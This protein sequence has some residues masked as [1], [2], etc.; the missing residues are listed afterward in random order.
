MV[1]LTT[2]VG[3][4]ATSLNAML[5]QIE[6]SFA[7]QR[8][9]EERMRRFVSDASHE[10]RTPLATVRGYGELYRIGGIPESQVSSAMVR[11]ESEATRMTG[12]VSDLLQLA[13]LDEGR[14]L[15]LQTV[16]LTG[17]ADDAAADVRVLDP[18]R[19][20]AV[21]GPDG[22]APAPVHAVADEQRVRQIL[23]N[24]TENA[25]MHTP[26]GT[27]VEIA[28]GSEGRTAVLEVRDHGPGV[29]P[30]ETERIFGRFYRLDSSRSR[31]SGGS[32]LGLAIVAAI[33]AAHGGTTR[34]SETP[35]G[36]LTITVTLPISRD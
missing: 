2:E 26:A 32:G 14:P 8:A 9:S 25:R 1:S 35:G 31:A 5:T 15:D 3:S 12:L 24:L 21:V 22:G 33:A 11:I 27:P 10:L 19:V 29:P 34:A 36:G 4:L 28:V 30:A 7:V 20:V 23:A 17:L 6:H 16:E 13:R 18:D